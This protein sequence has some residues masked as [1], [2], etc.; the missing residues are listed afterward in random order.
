MALYPN[1]AIYG[2]PHFVQPVGAAGHVIPVGG[3]PV[4]YPRNTALDATKQE[5]LDAAHRAHNAGL[6]RA[7]Y[8]ATAYNTYAHARE[9]NQIRYDQ[10]AARDSSEMARLGAI[11]IN[12]RCIATGALPLP[13][14]VEGYPHH[15]PIALHHPAPMYYIQQ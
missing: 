11:M 10:A 15:A 1:A 9:C 8:E 14:P 2:H 5:A 4:V 12:N 6:A 3:V 13:N 7:E